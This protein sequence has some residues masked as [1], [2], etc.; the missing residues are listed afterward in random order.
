LDLFYSTLQAQIPSGL[1]PVFESIDGGTLTVPE[2]KFH[3]DE[4]DLDLEYA[5]ALGK[6]QAILQELFCRLTTDV[7]HQ[8]ILKTLH[9]IRPE[10][11]CKALRLIPF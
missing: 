10:T 2:D 5:I 8:C 4:A 1:A 9:Y 11:L 6:S 7:F 3:N